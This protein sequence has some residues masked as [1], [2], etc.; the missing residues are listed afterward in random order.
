MEIKFNCPNPKCQQRISVEESRAGQSVSCPACG[1]VLQAPV[2]PN[3]KFI[4]SNEGCGQHMV[5]DVSE[6][7]RFVRCPS[8]GKMSQVPGSPPK[9]I[10]SERSSPTPREKPGSPAQKRRPL[11]PVLVPFKRLLFGWGAGAA[12]CILVI[13]GFYLHSWAALPPHLQ[14]MLEETYFHG[15]ILTAPAINHAETALLYV[16]TVETGAGVFLVN[17]AT[18]QRT[19]IALGKAAD[20]TRSGSIKLFG[21]SPD[22]RYLAFST[23][24]DGNDNR[25]VVICDGTLGKEIASFKAS[26]PVEMGTWL[27]GDS[28]VVLGN[29]R[30]SPK[31]F[32]FN[33]EQDSQ[34]GQFGK[35]GLVQL[36]QLNHAASC[37]VADSDQSISYVEQGNIWRLDIP[38]N[39]LIQLT[40]LTNLTLEGLDYSAAH[41]AYLFGAVD[42]HSKDRVLYQC[43]HRATETPPVPLRC[44]NY[45]FKGQ[46]LEDGMG[47]AYVGQV[48][49]RNYLAVAT[50]EKALCTNLFTAPGVL[51]TNWGR[52]TEHDFI[53]GREVVRSFSV[54]PKMDKIYTVASVNY[55]PLGIWEYDI[56][57]QKQ[58]N[59]VPVKERLVF[60]Q[61]IAPVEA[62]LTTAGGQKIDY[63]Y[64]PPARLDPKK[65]Y[66]VM[67]DVF[68]DLGFQASSQ[69]LANA[70]IMFVAVHPYGGGAPEKR[71]KW[72][73]C[74]PCT[75]RC[76]RIRTLIR[77]TFTSAE[78]APA[79]I[80]LPGSSRII[81]TSGAGQSFCHQRPFHQCRPTQRWF[82]AFLFRLAHKTPDRIYNVWSDMHWKRVVI[83][84]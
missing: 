34:L 59:V 23:I 38:A 49:N 75:M 73:I 7:G 74:W 56:A 25:H 48:G 18:L 1:T 68:S 19:Q 72:R 14:A 32:L 33:V 6:A 5:V 76:L 13:G 29:S 30:N 67:M 41:H 55:E 63:Y 82:Q 54:S 80:P 42:G 71:P 10:I 2:S 20:R 51:S 81:L 24:E 26:Q 65:K 36:R 39:Q 44:T 17:L 11:P 8:C 9:P 61:F 84:L 62:S 16:R 79:L 3:I 69:F 27:T 4:C 47:I 78:K 28:L 60:S 46:W 53:E 40:H 70:G 50:K 64:L 52:L 77:T 57:S 22:D 83:T 15:E 37:L 58:R 21:W 66:P 43:D 31:L 45:D 12:L 35:K